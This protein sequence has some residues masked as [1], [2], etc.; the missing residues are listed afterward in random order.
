MIFSK[1]RFFEAFAFFFIVGLLSY[2][3][4]KERIGEF[5]SFI[6]AWTQS[7][8]YAL[9]LGFINNGFDFFHPQTFNL[10]TINGI[11]QVDFPIHEYVVALIM[12]LTG[13][14]EPVIFRCYTLIYGIIGLYFLFRLTKFF[15]GTFFHGLFIAVFIMTCP[16][17]SYYLDGFLP[18]IPSFSN[19]IIGFYFYF[20]SRKNHSGRDFII[21]IFFLTLAA[22]SRMPFFIF[23]FAVCCQVLLEYFKTQKLIRKQFMM[24]V[25]GMFLVVFYFLYNVYLAKKYGSQFLTTILPAKNFGEMKEVISDVIS[26]WKFD[27]FSLAH[28]I[29]L[30]AIAILIIFIAAIKKNNSKNNLTGIYILIAF[31]GTIFYFLLMAKQFPEHDYY[32][33]DSFYPVLA[34]LLVYCLPKIQVSS[35]V[36]KISFLFTGCVL[37]FFFVKAAEK[38]LAD[39]YTVHEW[40]RGEITRQNF[41]GAENFLD[42]TGIPK[43]A[44]MLVLDAYTTNTPLILMNRKGYT[45]LWTSKENIDTAMKRDFD[46]VVMQN[47]FVVSDI[48]H[49]DPAIL[50]QL[51][52]ISDN[53]TISVYKKMNDENRSIEDFLGIKKSTIYYRCFSDFESDG[54]CAGLDSSKRTNE[55]YK[56]GTSSFKTE[57][58]EEYNPTFRFL[59]KEFAFSKSTK[60]F[61]RAMI[62]REDVEKD[63]DIVTSLN[64]GEETYFYRNFSINQY[65]GKAGGWQEMMFQF[66]LPEI[67]S[68]DD[69]LTVY[70][71]NNNKNKFYLDNFELTIYH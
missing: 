43:T 30:L 61:L 5:P 12:K 33:I 54:L 67:K 50:H 20:R 23:L 25:A 24:V 44:K 2:L 28:Y 22:L 35:V 31:C 48:I 10:V 36:T 29:T 51:E 19:V 9:A 11:T 53:G 71:W 55:K 3:F 18:S 13:I 1:N 42:K 34:L 57:P 62:F 39:R 15:G 52:K 59:K 7:D 46:F 64:H 49:F 47:C 8:R 32:F 4:F 17:F 26:R 70:I 27:Y 38:S 40:D 16:V 63:L 14:H 41:N 21:S 69:K 68:D 60:V 6:H 45:L 58:T 66:V 37:I 56:D 65:L